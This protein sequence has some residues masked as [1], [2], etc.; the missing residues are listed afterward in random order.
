MTRH[1]VVVAPPLLDHR[2]MAGNELA[3]RQTVVRVGSELQ[4]GRKGVE[5]TGG[6]RSS[7]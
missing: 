4:S 7:R 3:R 1:S 5:G 2:K 6:I